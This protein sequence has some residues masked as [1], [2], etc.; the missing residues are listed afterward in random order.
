LFSI[1]A[2]KLELNRNDLGTMTT[3]G[4]ILVIDDVNNVGELVDA[5]ATAL[6]LRWQAITDVSDLPER[7]TE[8]NIILLDPLIPKMDGIKV[9]RLLREQQC[10]AGIVLLSGGNELI[11]E[12]AE[13]LAENRGLSIAGHLRKPFPP[14]ALQNLLQRHVLRFG[15]NAATQDPGIYADDQELKNATQRN[16][17]V[18]HY[19]PQIEVA[20]GSVV[21]LEGLARWRHPQRGLIFPDAFI[22]GLRTLRL[23]HQFDRLVLDLD[24]SQLKQF[25]ENDHGI[26]RLTLRVTEDSLRD[27]QFPDTFEFLARYHRVPAQNVVMSFSGSRTMSRNSP[28]LD[29]LTRLRTKSVRLC[30]DDYESGYIGIQQLRDISATELKIS[31][32][33]VQNMFVNERDRTM[34][35][36]IIL[37][38]HELDMTVLAEGVETEQQLE[39]LRVKGCDYVQGYFF[40]HALH[41]ERMAAWLKAYR[42]RRPNLH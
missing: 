39:F 31:R 7:L 8:S 22:G 21:G 28:T 30:V 3:A 20:T 41:P 2:F 34:V 42:P 17:F 38:A 12:T 18:L 1:A 5:A 29:V 13:K 24:L 40:S 9:M 16:E 36:K 4:T 33:L 27:P 6:G 11:F 25:A 23:F 15:P 10:K 26:R 14:T 32:T 35:Q 19:R 37:I